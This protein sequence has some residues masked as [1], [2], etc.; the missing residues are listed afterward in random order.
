MVLFFSKMAKK[1]GAFPTD[2][3]PF[4]PLLTFK[5]K[6]TAKIAIISLI[7]QSLLMIVSIIK[8]C[9]KVVTSILNN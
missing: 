3:Y 4:N 5:Y 6:L 8:S 7:V 1:A 9:T 2:F